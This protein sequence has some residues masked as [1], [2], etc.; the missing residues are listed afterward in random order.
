MLIGPY[1]AILN[2]MALVVATFALLCTAQKKKKTQ[3]N[4]PEKQTRGLQNWTAAV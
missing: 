2:L 1:L 4:K 3:I